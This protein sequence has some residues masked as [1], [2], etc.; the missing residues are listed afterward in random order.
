ML[1][2]FSINHSPVL[3]AGLL[4]SRG[5]ARDGHLVGFEADKFYSGNFEMT[6]MIFVGLLVCDKVCAIGFHR[7]ICMLCFLKA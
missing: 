1:G 3:T 6:L 7:R 2:K 5:S 4:G